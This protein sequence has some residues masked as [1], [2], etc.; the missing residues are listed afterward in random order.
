MPKVPDG[1]VTIKQ[2]KFVK[3]YIA[4]DGNG[5]KAALEAYNTV[6]EKTASV[7]ASEN[8]EKPNIKLAIEQALIKHDITI[9]KATK[10]IA[11][12]LVATR[13]IGFGDNA[14][15]EI[16][17]STRLKASGMALK[18]MGAEKQSEIPQNAN[19]IQVNN[20]YNDRYK[21]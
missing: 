5:T 1:K 17:H 20:N 11:D 18:L 4:N 14:E 16:D 2:K 12:G 15:Y 10:P 13:K 19:F 21:D 3:A 6:D 9:E 8:L 7:I